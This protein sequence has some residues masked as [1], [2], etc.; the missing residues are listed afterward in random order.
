MHNTWILLQ[1]FYFLVSSEKLHEFSYY[2]ANLWL[3]ENHERSCFAQG[4]SIYH[5]I[6]QP[7]L[8]VLELSCHQKNRGPICK[9]LSHQDELREL[10]TPVER[11]ARNLEH[12]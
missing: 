8:L 7:L 5:A 3:Q 4:C 6:Y 1:L 10:H 12:S 11:L 9:S 2:L